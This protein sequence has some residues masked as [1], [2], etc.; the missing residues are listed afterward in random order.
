[1]GTQDDE[2]KS[3]RSKRFR[4]YETI[5]EDV[6]NRIGCDVEIN[7]MLK[8]RLREAGSNEDI[9]TYMA[10]WDYFRRLSLMRKV[11]MFTLK[12]ESH[13]YYQEPIFKGDSQDDHLWFMLKDDWIARKSRVLMDDVTR[14][15]SALIYYRDLDTTT[16]R[17]LIDSKGRIILEDPQ[18]G[19]PIVGI[20]RPPRASMYLGLFE[21]MAGVYSVL[22]QGAYNPPAFAQPQYDQYYQQYPPLPPGVKFVKFIIYPEE[23]D[24]EPGVIL[25]RT[26]L[27]E[28]SLD[29]W[30]HLLDFNLDDIPLLG[31]EELPP[32]EVRHV[33]KTMAY[34]D[35]YKKILDEIWKD[36]VELDGMIV[37]EEEE[38]VKRIKGEA[39][40]EKDDPRAFIFSVRLEGKVNK[41]VLADTGSDINTMPYRIYETLGRDEMKKVD[42]GITMIN[43]TQ[44]E[45][46]GVL[47]NVLCQVGVTTINAKFLILDIPFDHDAPIVVGR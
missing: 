39:L 35:K 29:D 19:V 20:P 24:V 8:I 41:N 5:E 10:C 43:H 15:L 17:D 14:S 2:A 22:L 9:F 23:D 47:T 32:F 13:F 33:I 46:F 38:S 4:R 28:K 26:F 12:E 6:L 42:R 3:S 27:Q 36:R 21:K 44:A 7:D 16:L 45:A 34:H 25:G 18:P 11:L 30:E 37:K 40:K 1:M 31:E